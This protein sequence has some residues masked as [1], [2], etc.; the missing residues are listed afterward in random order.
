[1]PSTFRAVDFSNSKSEEDGLTLNPYQDAA[2]VTLA[3]IGCPSSHTEIS[4]SF[5]G[6]Q[7]SAETSGVCR[8]LGSNVNA[9]CESDKPGKRASM[10]TKSPS[11]RQRTPEQSAT[12][13]KKEA[14]KKGEHSR[15]S[16]D[17]SCVKNASLE[18]GEVLIKAGND[19]RV[20][21]LI[22]GNAHKPR[23]KSPRRATSLHK[24]APDEISTNPQRKLSKERSGEIK[25]ISRL[26][27]CFKGLKQK[28][29]TGSLVE[30][31]INTAKH[32][33]QNARIQRQLRLPKAQGDM[34]ILS[35]DA[36]DPSNV[37]G[38]AIDF[39]NL[40][41]DN[42]PECSENAINAT[43][44][45]CYP[46]HGS[47][48][49]GYP[50]IDKMFIDVLKTLIIQ[51]GPDSSPGVTSIYNVPEGQGNF[52]YEKSC[53]LKMESEIG[54]SNNAATVATVTCC[55][56]ESCGDRLRNDD[57]AHECYPTDNQGAVV[58]SGETQLCNENTNCNH[59]I[60]GDY[61]DEALVGYD[62]L[63]AS[64]S[65]EDMFDAYEE[66]CQDVGS[67]GCSDAIFRNVEEAGQLQRLCNKVS[68][69]HFQTNAE[70]NCDV[71][72]DNAV[73][74]TFS[75]PKH[76]I[77]VNANVFNTFSGKRYSRN[78]NNSLNDDGAPDI[79]CKNTDSDEKQTDH[80]GSKE[81]AIG[82]GSRKAQNDEEQSTV[83]NSCFQYELLG[84]EISFKISP[85]SSLTPINSSGSESVVDQFLSV[86]EAFMSLRTRMS[87]LEDLKS[88]GDPEEQEREMEYSANRS[89][90][91]RSY[92][93]L[94]SSET[95]QRF[96]TSYIETARDIIK[97]AKARSMNPKNIFEKVNN[98]CGKSKK[99]IKLIKSWSFSGVASLVGRASGYTFA[100]NRSKIVDL[101]TKWGSLHEDDISIIND[102]EISQHSGEQSAL[103]SDRTY[104]N[105]V[106]VMQSQ[107]CS[108]R[109][110]SLTS[111]YRKQPFQEI[112]S[113]AAA[114]NYTTEEHVNIHKKA[115]D[116]ELNEVCTIRSAYL[117]NDRSSEPQRNDW[118]RKGHTED[119]QEAASPSV[120]VKSQSLLQVSGTV[121]GESRLSKNVMAMLSQEVTLKRYP[122][123]SDL[124]D[125]NGEM[126]PGAQT[127]FRNNGEMGPG[128]QSSFRNNGEHQFGISEHMNAAECVKQNNEVAPGANEVLLDKSIDKKSRKAKILEAEALK[129]TPPNSPYMGSVT[130]TKVQTIVSLLE[131][132]SVLRTDRERL[133]A[134]ESQ[135][136]QLENDA[137]ECQASID[138]E[139]C[140][141]A[142]SLPSPPLSSPGD[143][144]GDTLDDIKYPS[145]LLEPFIASTSKSA[146]A[147]QRH[148]MTTVNHISSG[149]GEDTLER[150]IDK[151][152]EERLQKPDSKAVTLVRTG[153]YP[154]MDTEDLPMNT[155]C[156]GQ[157]SETK[158]EEENSLSLSVS[159]IGTSSVT[160][161]EEEQ[162]PEL[163]IKFEVM[164]P[165]KITSKSPKSFTGFKTAAK[166]H[167]VCHKTCTLKNG[168][169][170]L[171]K[172]GS[173][174][175]STKDP[176]G[177]SNEDATCTKYPRKIK[178]MTESPS[179]EESGRL[180]SS[181]SSD[182]SEHVVKVSTDKSKVN[183][184]I[185][186]TNEIMGSNFQA[187]TTH[188]E[189]NTNLEAEDEKNEVALTPR[190]DSNNN[191]ALPTKKRRLKLHHGFSYSHKLKLQEYVKSEPNA[192]CKT[193]KKQSHDSDKTPKKPSKKPKVFTQNPRPQHSLTSTAEVDDNFDWFKHKFRLS[194][195]SEISGVS[196]SEDN[197]M[198]K[199]IIAYQ[200][201]SESGSPKRVKKLGSKFT[202]VQSKP[203]H[204]IRKEETFTSDPRTTSTLHK[205]RQSQS[206]QLHNSAIP[207]QPLRSVGDN[208]CIQ[209]YKHCKRR[210]AATPM[211]FK[212][213][214][215]KASVSKRARG[216]VKGEI[217][218]VP[219][220]AKS[221]WEETSALH[222][223]EDAQGRSTNQQPVPSRFRANRSDS[224]APNANEFVRRSSFHLNRCDMMIRKSTATIRAS[225]KMVERS[226][227]R[228]A[229]TAAE[230][231]RLECT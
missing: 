208:N 52:S 213:T 42:Y 146:S 134:A 148:A 37:L 68:H 33:E 84:N 61:E 2:N 211:F 147:S 14:G 57:L 73:H 76:F 87:D 46:Y 25:T 159:D 36:I 19:E 150:P 91:L 121:H 186:P 34:D 191:V 85:P 138:K 88:N 9:R 204:L 139:R 166:D 190:S 28:T 35:K 92:F 185:M 23:E 128:A 72:V 100:S 216:H 106:E 223:R 79:N 77:D 66:F 1:M 197:S 99:E 179:E 195:S 20:S 155:R 86:P 143:S 131:S 30:N 114:T 12:L 116:K 193:H 4:L 196:D 164:R 202:H 165:T 67:V 10:P 117:E 98:F 51:S 90:T 177:S 32:L 187:T 3:F 192:A 130:G 227:K 153:T 39:D 127:L 135:N 7:G 102:D 104:D 70:V 181:S 188:G 199:T 212:K 209:T 18:R 189:N 108:K 183:Y 226:K 163:K 214:S 8:V 11:P 115:P 71:F 59:S 133:V 110:V 6:S 207:A 178:W 94:N 78:Q 41:L 136:V 206:F 229:D 222:G 95:T 218:V 119:S 182:I 27:A 169:K 120:P 174:K 103:S 65:S 205:M 113:S 157:A 16:K 162:P 111:K 5:E 60:E 144:T 167:Q 17:V 225:Q 62:P 24:N 40:N 83:A 215:P 56:G 137:D 123:F 74:E 201:A 54:K 124:T 50:S 55:L 140:A 221:L 43:A 129:K 29:Q 171:G 126:G 26:R 64:N 105:H 175:A 109:Y 161:S 217:C 168:L 21:P 44:E 15:R 142:L 48:S 219:K 145:E 151:S 81:S 38:S 118:H 224:K 31:E 80:C 210:G 149:K 22:F 170:R 58:N 158:G 203:Y 101:E 198:E 152:M 107:G 220:V 173:V 89:K 82:P 125:I 53:D 112:D 172:F 231:K 184:L 97:R 176:N 194:Q 154:G 63:S 180:K 47:R 45:P 96:I 93:H 75:S 13:D 228:L 49:K 69:F 160:T 230:M 122:S 156:Y 141:G 200:Y 132:C